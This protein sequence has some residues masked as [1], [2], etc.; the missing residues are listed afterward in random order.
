MINLHGNWR[1]Y[2]DYNNNGLKEEIYKQVF[3]KNTFVMPGTTNQNRIGTKLDES[4]LDAKEK[5]KCLREHY[6]FTGI[7]WYQ[8]EIIVDE[9]LLFEDTL[10]FL[11][12]VMFESQV[13]INGEFVGR[14]SSLSTPHR[15]H[16]K[17]YLKIG[18][19]HI[20][21]RVDNTDVEDIGVYASAMTIDT[22]TVWNGII[23]KMYIKSV[24]KKDITDIQIYPNLKKENVLITF[25]GKNINNENNDTVL[26]IQAVSK[27]KTHEVLIETMQIKNDDTYQ[28]TYPMKD[29]LVWNEFTPNMYNLTIEFT[30]ITKEIA[31]G[32]REIKTDKRQITIN[33]KP[34]FLLGTLECCIFP[35]TGYP[36]TTRPY[37]EKIMNTLKEYGLNHIRFHSWCP[38]DI[39]FTVAD[40]VGIYIQAEGPLW[41]D[42]WQGTVIGSSKKHYTYI[43]EENKRIMKEYGN[44][45]SFVI[46]SNGNE[47][48]G[49]F[50]LLEQAI[51]EVKD[52]KRRLYTLTS[53][54]D[55]KMNKE[56]DIFISQTVDNVGIR[57]QYFHNEMATGTTL[58]FSKGVNL[59]DVPI[60]THEV[61]QYT[62]FPDIHEIPK[63]SG[64]LEPTNL[65]F[66]KQTMINNN[67]EHLAKQYTLNSGKTSYRLYKDE[68]ESALRTKD[69]AGIQL[70]DLHDFPG[71]S[72]ADVGILDC[73][74][75]SKG[76][77]SS[78]TFKECTDRIVPLLK[79]PKRIYQVSETIEY[80]IDISNYSNETLNDK[81][82]TL[83][84]VSEDINE[85][86]KY[87]IDNIKQGNVY[88]Y[89]NDTFIIKDIKTSQRVEAI[90]KIEGTKYINRWDLF[91]YPNEAVSDSIIVSEVN[92][93]FYRLLDE[94]SNFIFNPMFDYVKD[95][96]PGKFFPV[97]WSPVHFTS[98]N[99]N[100]LIIEKEHPI[101]STFCTD[102]FANY[103]WKSLVDNSV[104]MDISSKN[105]DPIIDVI[106]N[107]I[108]SK[109]LTNLFE[110]QVQDS[111]IIVALMDISNN[112]THRPVA[113]SLHNS[114][115]AYLLNKKNTKNNAMTIEEF[116]S[117]FYKPGEV[118]ESSNIPGSELGKGLPSTSS[119]S[120]VG[121]PVELGNNGINYTFWAANDNKTGHH[122]EIDLQKECLIY[123]T[124]V[125]FEKKENYLYVIRVSND[126][127]NY[128]TVVNQT[129]QTSNEQTR[130][131]LFNARGRF[132]QIVYNGL[133]EGI[134]AGHY[135]FEVYGE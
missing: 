92:D 89:I 40:E 47:L 80:S 82:I 86:R 104:N 60:I 71:Q 59:R 54:W 133:P 95:S 70:L 134:R 50:D 26:K 67:I 112:L 118:K 18:K 121:H 79:M 72:T 12:R 3:S 100:G 105:I 7:M 99:A 106:P 62:I 69:L 102:D 63:Y 27:H 53:N 15:Y 127:I 5:V 87:N 110:V 2:I 66:I 24:P 43:P 101:F 84:L 57:G 34:V 120:H 38:P 90:V 97:F 31:F 1:Y 78:E 65:K 14:N 94:K 21:I 107:F 81:I 32:M 85:V 125:I 49:D 4:T 96:I 123:G 39:A 119:S 25:K 98:D 103:Q 77:I 61:G 126:G 41:M 73:F 29:Y 93:D 46:F 113:K 9:L 8:K 48:N 37:W 23:G 124:K 131:D 58:E 16:I 44:H 116:T 42:T 52:D 128:K 19:N 11:E 109:R 17:N 6:N 114:I 74:W 28:I 83:T 68:I 115:S 30:N 111:T 55:R 88:N 33:D 36:E 122:F 135:A 45:P 35:L 132:I 51:R 13:F 75:D 76:I 56:D 108:V 64:L 117:M 91:I 129:G 130:M 10:L 22:Q 20:T